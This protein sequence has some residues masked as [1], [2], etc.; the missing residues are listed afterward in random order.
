MFWMGCAKVFQSM[1]CFFLLML[2]PLSPVGTLEEYVWGS[3]VQF[4]PISCPGTISPPKRIF[5]L[6]T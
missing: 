5:G 2:W 3:A 1:Y 4:P 6:T